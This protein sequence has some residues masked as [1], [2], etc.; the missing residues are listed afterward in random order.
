MRQPSSC[1][2]LTR[3]GVIVDERTETETGLPVR[4]FLVDFA[5]GVVPACQGWWFEWECKRA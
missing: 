2:P 1:A 4:Q 5:P 3:A